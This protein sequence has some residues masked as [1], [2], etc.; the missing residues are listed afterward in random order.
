MHTDQ[1]KKVRIPALSI[2]AS[3]DSFVDEAFQKKFV[4]AA[5]GPADSVWYA[6]GAPHSLRGWEDRVVTDT[7]AWEGRRITK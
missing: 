2:T 7:L 4:Q 1:I 6:D 5:G 3:N